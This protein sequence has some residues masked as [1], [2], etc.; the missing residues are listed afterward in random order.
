MYIYIYMVYLCKG[1]LLHYYKFTRGTIIQTSTLRSLDVQ[2]SR[3]F[4]AL[5]SARKSTC[6]PKDRFFGVGALHFDN[7]KESVREDTCEDVHV[8][9]SILV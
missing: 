4:P 1:K 6:P 7:M 5:A 3:N 2:D 8:H 9:S